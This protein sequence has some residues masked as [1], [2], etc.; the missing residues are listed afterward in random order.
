MTVAEEFRDPE[1]PPGEITALQ[2]EAIARRTPVMMVGNVVNVAATLVALALTYR[3]GTD[4]T[5]WA[6]AVVLYSSWMLASWLRHR[7]KPFPR[8]LSPRTRTRLV[9]FATILGALWA[10]LGL[11]IL[12]EAPPITQA[13]LITM[14]AGMVA[15]G[16]VTLYPVPAAALAYGGVQTA[17]YLWGFSLTGQAVIWPFAVVA[18]MFFIVIVWSV[19]RHEQVFVSEF[20]T[21]RHLDARNVVV[22]ELLEETRSEAVRQKREAE[23]RLAHAQRLDAVGRLSAGIAHDFNNLLAAIM[24]NIELAR[25]NVRDGETDELLGSALAATERGAEL[26]QQMLAFGRKAT[27][28]P[29]PLEPRAVVADLGSLLERTLPPSITIETDLADDGRPV[30]VDSAQLRTALLNLVLNA[31]DAMPDGGMVR[32]ATSTVRVGPEH[33]AAGGAEGVAPGGYVAFEVSDAGVGVPPEDLERVFEPF[34]TTKGVGQ[35]TGLGLAMVY[36]FARQSGGHCTLRSRPGEGTTVTV[37]LPVWTGEAPRSEPSETGGRR[38]AM[39]RGR[40][41]RILVVEDTDSVRDMLERQLRMLGFVPITAPDGAT[42]LGMLRG[43][44]EVDMLLTDL[45]MPGTPQGPDLAEMA[46]EEGLV[47]RVAFISGYPK[48]MRPD[49]DG[50]LADV[51]ILQKPIGIETLSRTMQETLSRP[52]RRR[53]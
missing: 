43:G 23:A 38:W 37:L 5:L 22:Q 3:I 30:L 11:A 6:A 36:G 2:V 32:L 39:P 1:I 17:A 20:V 41:E 9:V 29:E 16:A 48:G 44:L 7:G 28:S 47:E 53:T 46:L 34:F 12:P 13:Y 33:E 14:C 18:L 15:S 51:P 24:G 35:G 45:V 50:R 31:R 10:F 4:G 27:L 26:V 25:L 21:R 40:S 42:A 19:R 49:A 8:T 52:G